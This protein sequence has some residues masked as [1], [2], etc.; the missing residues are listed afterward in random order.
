MSAAGDRVAPI[1]FAHRGGKA[2]APEN[3]LAA[4]TNALSL[5]ATGLESDVWLTRDGVAVLD[6][7]GVILGRR[8]DSSSRKWRRSRQDT[9]ISA[10]A[11]HE[12]P[13]HVPSLSDLYETCGTDFELSI[14]VKD[15]A[16]AEPAMA[17]AARAGALGRLWLCTASRQLLKRWRASSSEVRL[18]DSV[19]LASFRT[20][21]AARIQALAPIGA[22]A[23]NV[24]HRGW[25]AA[26]VTAVHAAGRRAFAWD[27]QRRPVLTRL[28]A[29]GI[30]GIFSDH[31]DRLMAAVRG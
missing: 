15:P 31:V 14:D 27:A 17:V 5:G 16:A 28:V 12:L 23:L 1:G 21:P 30:D 6:H 18:V 13:E 19:P 2:H 24:H 10:L 29:L 22:D 8:A 26:H 7:D 25:T 4:F 20:D 3:T 11:R 9:P